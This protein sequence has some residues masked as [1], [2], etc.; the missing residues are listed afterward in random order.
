M[1]T[2][3]INR[4]Y[5]SKLTIDGNFTYLDFNVN[6][7]FNFVNV[8]DPHHL[9]KPWT[10]E[11][12]DDFRD[13]YLS[14]IETVWN[15]QIW[16]SSNKPWGTSYYDWEFYI[17]KPIICGINIIIKKYDQSNAHQILRVLNRKPIR[18]DPGAAWMNDLGGSEGTLMLD[19]ND[20]IYGHIKGG[21]PVHDF[22]SAHEFGH[23]LGFEHVVTHF[24]LEKLSKYE[25]FEKVNVL[26]SGKMNCVLDSNAEICYR[27]DDVMGVQMT[28][29]KWHAKPWID[30][31]KLHLGDAS[32]D[33]VFTA[34]LGIPKGAP[35][36]LN[37]RL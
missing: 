2:T 26:I 18:S 6:T 34:N 8:T 27:G 16:L 17:N 28:I 11:M 23:F 5:N 7:Y 32:D 24:E 4:H 10:R 3:I 13:K 20:E 35:F 25:G 9:Y 14:A 1:E 36:R 21:I 29:N 33:L 37:L 22:P 31:I 30:R 15:N 19:S 12:K